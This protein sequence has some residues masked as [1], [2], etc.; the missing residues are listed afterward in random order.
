MMGE[1]SS[2]LPVRM[3]SSDTMAV[4]D[5]LGVSSL[6]RKSKTFT[7]GPD[8]GG[9]AAVVAAAGTDDSV[10]VG[11]AGGGRGGRGGRGSA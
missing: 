7:V 2:T 4:R 1:S 3:V 5:A 6:T 9:T 8:G 11:S 10:D